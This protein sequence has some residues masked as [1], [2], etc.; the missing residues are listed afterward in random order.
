MHIAKNLYLDLVENVEQHLSIVYHMCSREP[1]DVSTG[2]AA[3]QP[4]LPL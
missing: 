4:L 3:A 2:S 1:S